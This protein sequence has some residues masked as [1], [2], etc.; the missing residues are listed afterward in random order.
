M[1]LTLSMVLVGHSTFCLGVFT[2]SYTLMII[3]RIING[4]GQ[5]P[6]FV[7]LYSITKRFVHEDNLL[8]IN[9]L[10]L[11]C[12]RAIQAGAYF[13]NPWLYLQYKNFNLILVISIAILV[14]S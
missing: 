7:A 9:S 3:G 1:Y 10:L 12:S 6:N 4:S 14:L 8:I 11:V 13:V 2:T 5:E